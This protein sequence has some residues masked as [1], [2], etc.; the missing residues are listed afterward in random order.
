MTD[1][2]STAA[3]VLRSGDLWTGVLVAAVGAVGLKAAFDIFQP[4]GFNSVLGPR[5][6]PIAVSTLLVALGAL[7]AL[8]AV[9]RR[10]VTHLDLGSPSALL[11]VSAAL[12]GYLTVFR[13]LGFVVATVLFLTLLFVYLGERKIW[14]AVTAGV[15]LSAVVAAAFS[16][17]LNVAL[18]RGLFGF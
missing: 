11:V 7:L 16:L 9:V 18:P 5:A 17:G 10:Q 8:R 2:Q 15:V 12:A 1:Q 3:P 13:L 14:V 4:T 6:F